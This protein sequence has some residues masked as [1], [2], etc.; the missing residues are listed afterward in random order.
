MTP[1]I[2]MEKQEQLSIRDLVADQDLTT[3]D[4]AM[5]FELAARVKAV[6]GSFSHALAGKQ[7][8]MIFEKPSLRTRVTFE[9]GMTSM[10]GYAIYLEHSKPR[11]GERESIKDVAR[12]LSRWVDGIVART[13]AH[14]AVVELAENASIPVINALTDLLHPCQAL[15]DYFTLREKFGSLKGLKLA[16]VGDG[17]NVCHSLMLT[18]AKL[19]V[20]VRVA[21]PYGFEPKAEIVSEAKALG[22]E[23][24]AKIQLFHDP[25]EAVAGTQAVYTDVWASMGQ[26]YAAH[27]RTQVFASYQVN[28][29]LMSAAGP[30]T[31]FLHCLPAH[32]GSEVTDAVID[33][34]TSLVYDQAENRLHVQKALLLLLLQPQR[35]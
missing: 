24:G 32:R 8:A 12:N 14:Q 17:N 29:N 34:P 19:G 15:G 25:V 11:L 1:V 22:R 18:G 13:F 5:I 30:D 26:E 16:F 33:S 3:A 23:T 35:V 28:E 9:V 31:V 7:L 27:L 10:G 21:T 6:P 2:A 20:T 4:L